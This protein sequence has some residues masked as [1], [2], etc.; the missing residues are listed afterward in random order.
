MKLL[1][2]LLSPFD[3][4]ASGSLENPAINDPNT[5]MTEIFGGA[6]TTS[7]ERVNGSTAMTV[8]AYL[9]A[10][11]NISEDL[12]KEPWVQYRIEGEKRIR[13]LDTPAAKLL[14]RPNPWMTAMSFREALVGNAL[15]WGGGY[16]EIQRTRR[17]KPL[18]LHPIHPSRVTPK[19]R[20]DGSVY[21]EVRIDDL[22]GIASETVTL[23]YRE[24]LH[25]KGFSGDGLVGYSMIRFAAEALGIALAAQ[26][27]AA[28][29]YGNGARPAGVLKHPGNLSTPAAERLRQ[30]FQRVYGG[31]KN[32]GKA[33]LLEEGMEWLTISMPM[34]EAQFLETRRFQVEEFCR[35][36]R[37]PPHKLQ[38]LEKATFSNIEHLSIEYVRDT[39]S[40]WAER[41]EQEWE[42]KLVPEAD[43]D[44]TEIGVDFRNTLRGDSKTQ[45]EVA[46]N[47]VA[48]GIWSPNEGR[49]EQGMNPVDDPAA[50]EHYIQMNM[51]TLAIAAKEPEP[52]APPPATEPPK[53]DESDAP[54]DADESDD[55]KPDESTS[56]SLYRVRN[57]K[58]FLLTTQRLCRMEADRAAKAGAKS[59]EALRSFYARHRTHLTE[60][61]APLV[62]AAAE[63]LGYCA[64]DRI[65]AL[66][67]SMK[68]YCENRAEGRAG[69]TGEPNHESLSALVL[70]IA[71]NR[72]IKP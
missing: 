71:T 13:I 21:Y 50:D 38:H 10:I 51:T 40:P 66:T 42:N 28:A 1:D 26:R 17:G 65:S 30:E 14:R 24:M 70:A 53:P 23:D 39:L 11:R 48:S 4:L 60:A 62:E 27:T 52:P 37:I 54:D 41:V 33:M 72:E 47:N 34:E 68:L 32:V 45:S 61:F 46:R 12:A 3:R 49:Q 69:E 7:G 29:F 18:W 2:I 59:N 43:Y 6:R 5:W 44:G 55:A 64:E 56:A 19:R 63:T 16:A 36:C 20:A 67:A 57:R 31:S 35:I 15:S 8:P 9:A 22:R 25:V 58:V